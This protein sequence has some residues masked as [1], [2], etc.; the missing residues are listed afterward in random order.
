VRGGGGGVDGVW[1]SGRGEG[2][3]KKRGGGGRGGM[4]RWVWGG[5]WVMVGGDGTLEEGV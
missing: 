3:G 1:R 5:G 2:G 4:G